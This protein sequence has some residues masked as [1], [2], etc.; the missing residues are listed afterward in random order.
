M[1]WFNRLFWKIFLAFWLASLSVIIVTV[2]V[3]GE[4]A[5]RDS[6]HE[7]FEYRAKGQA[8]KI[9]ARFEAGTLRFPAE[10][11]T[12]RHKDKNQHHTINKPPRRLPLHIYDAAGALVFGKSDIRA[13][14][15]VMKFGLTSAS[16][17]TYSVS[18]TLDPIRTHFARLQ[19]F[20]F[21]FQAVLVLITSTVAS[22][23]LSAIVV[24]PVNKLRE[25]VEQFHGGLMSARVEPALLS[26]GDEIGALAREFDQMAQYVEHTMQGQQRLL[27]DVSHE[28]R[29]PLARLQVA[30]GLVEQKLGSDSKITQ[31]INL[32]CE[33]LSKLIDEM[34][35]LARLD[36][37]EAQESRF[38]VAKVVDEALDD[39]QFSQPDRKITVLNHL[40]VPG[41]CQGNAE[42][43][44]RA[45][46]NVLGN[47]LKHTRAD[48]AVDVEITLADKKHMSIT[49]RD[50]GEG[51]S[52]EALVSLFEP[53]Y[54][55]NNNANSFGL[56]L[57]IAKR[58]VE[59]L[60]GTIQAKNV[61]DGFAV[62]LQLPL[63]SAER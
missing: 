16:G 39:I 25:H 49:I 27:Q 15:Q 33:R 60:N 56:G 14:D 22:I 4:I 2:L 59:R 32:E 28:L 18:V 62:I 23:L 11:K 48:C 55:H 19:G 24:R 63:A 61:D 37:I 47:I 58:A 13:S 50:H 7:V 9:I 53:F 44:M 12:F 43:L 57:S 10:S 5:E 42:L 8:E 38:H 34:L 36:N 1:K 26:R 20:L 21:S 31:R 41:Y 46:S 17:K 35:T 45:L 52:E 3:V 40:L 29:A 30:T 6:V 54:R 51:V